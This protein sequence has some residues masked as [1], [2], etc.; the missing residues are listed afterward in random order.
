MTS[1]S[2]IV[3]GLATAAA[4]GAVIGLLF[5]PEKGTEIRDK[6]RET[7]NGFASDLLDALQRGRQ[8][9]TDIKDN[10]ED[11]AKE[12]KSKADEKITEVKDRVSEEAENAKNK[13]QR[14][15]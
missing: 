7:A 14:Y 11:K 10:V 5:A 12:L 2:K 15:A 8:Q 6:V 9:Y 4:A 13:A 1:N 3:L